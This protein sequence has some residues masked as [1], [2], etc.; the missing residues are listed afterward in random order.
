MKG[1]LNIDVSVQALTRGL[2][3]VHIHQ[4]PACDPPDFRSAGNHF[5][6][7]SKQHGWHNPAGHHAGDF[8]E[9]IV[10]DADGNGHMKVTLYD[11]N[12]ALGS[13]HTVLGRSIVIHERGDDMRTEP[14][15]GSGNRIACGVIPF[16]R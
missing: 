4:N 11:L 6:P 2:H 15:G 9:N 1:G 13:A 3:A 5:N 14:S 16:N 7:D 8:T 12:L 10:V